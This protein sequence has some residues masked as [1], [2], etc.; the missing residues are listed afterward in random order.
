MPT[1]FASSVE[2]FPELCTS[3][4]PSQVKFILNNHS[5]ITGNIHPVP[6]DILVKKQLHFKS[7]EFIY[8]W[9]VQKIVSD[10]LLMPHD[11]V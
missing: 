11:K 3:I 7:L 8:Y 10:W 2:G 9:V 1:T 4:N 6:Y 5:F